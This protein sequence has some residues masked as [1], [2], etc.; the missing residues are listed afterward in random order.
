MSRFQLAPLRN[1]NPSENDDVNAV[2]VVA[3][4][5]WTCCVA[6]DVSALLTNVAHAISLGARGK[7]NA[8]ARAST[9]TS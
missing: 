4:T 7:P 1:A 5:V 6:L 2:T 8:I 9:E 3:P